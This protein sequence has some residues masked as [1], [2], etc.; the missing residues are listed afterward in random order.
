MPRTPVIPAGSAPRLEA[1]GGTLDD[2]D[3]NAIL[4]QDLADPAAGNEA[5][6]EFFGTNPPARYCLEAKLVTPE[7]LVEISSVAHLG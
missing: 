3:D 6:E 4:R 2:V 5:H 7:F 1:A